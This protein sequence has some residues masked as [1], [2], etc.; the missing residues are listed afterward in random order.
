MTW[1]EKVKERD[2][3][4][5]AV[6]GSTNRLQAHHIK[7]TFLYPECKND[8]DNGITLCK[9][10]HQI[11]H[12]DNFSSCD[13]LSINGI[14]PDPEGRIPAYQQERNNRREEK[15]KAMAGYHITWYS[16]DDNGKIVVKAAKAAK[17]C[18]KRYI[19]EAISM[20]LKAEGYEHDPEIFVPSYRDWEDEMYMNNQSSKENTTK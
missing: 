16:N 20:R 8:I 18:P 5:C 11:H 2:G 13:M 7:P 10:C 4:R 1:S 9:E 12:G 15:K 17:R 19:A 3:W 6:C 14:D